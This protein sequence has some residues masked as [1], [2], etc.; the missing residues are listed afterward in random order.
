MFLDI[1][2]D[3]LTPPSRRQ[4]FA[5]GGLAIAGA[6]GLT[7]APT[8]PRLMFGSNRSAF[9][10]FNTAIPR[11]VAV[12]VYYDAENQFPAGWPNRLPGAWM[13]LSLRPNP[14]DLL[15]GKLDSQ[16]KAIIDSAP[17]HSEL[18]FWH[19]NTT[20]NPL[21][22]PSY[23]NNPR[24]ALLMQ[25]YGQSLCSGTK[26]RFGVITCGPVGQQAG[27]IAPGLDWYGDDL[28][29]FPRL[30]NPD[31]TLNQAKI[32]AR[33]DANLQTWR[34]RSGQHRPSLRI[35]ETNSP[36]DSHRKNWFT[37]LAQWM[38]A[39][40]GRRI[41]TYWNP[42]RGLANNGLSGPWPPTQNVVDRLHQLSQTY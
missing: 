3:L 27:W 19:E 5:A 23:V 21:G 13:T 24:A 26:V 28:Y 1:A 31:G 39:H 11:G 14:G 41:L 10:S 22:Y 7:S 30:R 34:K 15:A 37:W 8:P 33:L 6:A 36:H 32:Y 9:P 38:A 16:L 40:N 42:D 18:T 29:D 4:A 2:T 12:R 20:G 35:C 25:H 17:A